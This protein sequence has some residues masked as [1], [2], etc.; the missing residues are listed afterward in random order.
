[1]TITRAELMAPTKVSRSAWR[2]RHALWSAL[3][4]EGFTRAEIARLA[5]RDWGTVNHGIRRARERKE[6]AE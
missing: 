2:D 4:R 5:K 3:N 1:M 6:A